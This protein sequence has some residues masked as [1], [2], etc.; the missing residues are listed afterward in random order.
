[1]K[2]IISI[3][4]AVT[5]ILWLVGAGL[6]ALVPVAKAAVVD[7]DVVS[8]DATFVDADGNTYYSYDVFIVKIVGTK[9]FKRLVLNPQ[10]FDSYGHLK[11]SNIKKIAAA[12]VA[13]YTTSSIV[14]EIN[15]TKVY[16]LVPDGDTGTKQW[17]DDLACFTSKAYDW[18]SVY[19]INATDRDNYTTGSSLCGVAVAGALTLSLASD[20]PAA[21]TV[22]PN[23]QGLTFLKVNV[24]GSGTVNQVT[25]TRKG[26]GDVGDFGD[27]YIYKDGVRLTSG[28]SLSS[29]TS[30]VTFINLG[31]AAPTTFDV[32]VDMSTGTAGNINYFIIESASEVTADATIGGTFPISGNPMGVSGTNAGTITM[33]RSGAAARNVT[34]GATEQEISQFK[35]TTATEGAYVKIVR[36]FNGG[37]ADNNLITNLK[38]KN[39]AGTTVATATS[40]SS[41]GYADFV[42][43]TPFFISKGDNEIFRVYA[44]IGG[45]KPD[46]TVILYAEIATDILATGNVYGYGMAATI[47]GFD[48]TGEAVTVTC[49]G[50]DLTLNDLGPNAANIG[51]TSSDTVFLE[52]SMTAAADITIKR[53][54]LI[55]CHDDTGN[56]TYENASGSAGADIED[57]KIRNK[58][59]GVIVVG[60]KDG[61]AFNDATRT[62]CP[63]TKT[64]VYEDFTDTIDISAGE[65]KTYQVTGDIKVA[66]TDSGV[67]IT[68]GDIIKFILYS[69]ASLVGVSGNVN[70]MKYAGTSDAVDDSAIA[71]SGDIAGEQMTIA[72]PSLAL[73]LGASPSGGDAT[74]DEKV[75]IA[76]QSGVEAVGIVFTAGSAS[77]ITINSIQLTGYTVEQTGGAFAAGIDTNYVK[78]T[79]AKVYIYDKSTGELVTGS[80][81]KGFTS[82]TSFEQVDY[83]GLSWVIPAGTQKTLLVKADISSAA[84]ASASSADTWISFDIATAADD[85]TAIDKDGNSVTTTGDAPNGAAGTDVIV[86]FGVADYGTL[87]IDQ[88]T[89]TPDKSLAV[90]GTTDNEVSKF[91]LSGVSEA[92]Y[93]EKFSIVLDDGGGIDTDDR[94]NFSAVKVKYQTESQ[95]GTSNWTISSG[96]TFGSTASLAFTF[97]GSDRVYVPKDNDTYVTILASIA[98]YNGGM[99]AKSKVPFKLYDIDG[100]D[101]SLKAYGAQSGK[102]LTEYSTDSAAAADFNLHFVTR[103]KPVFAKSAWS[104]GELEL[105]RF[106]ITAVGYDVIFDG[107]T[108][109]ETDYTSAALRFDVVASS[110]DA[111][112]IDL[113]LYDWNENIVAST[114]QTFSADAGTLDGFDGSVTS[115]SF[116]FEERDATVPAGTTKEFHIDIDAGSVADFVKTDEYIYLQLRNDDGGNLATG[117]M[118]FGE[119]DAVFHDGTAEEGI[120]SVDG[121]GN[122][123]S[124]FGMPAL[125]KNIGPLP[126]TFRTLRG[127]ATP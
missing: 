89:D 56:G 24:S 7:G 78:D 104:G 81:A 82:G 74:N 3:T 14:R 16:K 60:P 35:L 9:T 125:I 34:I 96:K 43:S 92:W 48:T 26:A 123:E 126:I 90:M 52:Y 63:G 41:G 106:T 86:N 49:K 39:T 53:T 54:E 45:T 109:T 8:P 87:T 21:S 55:F 28:R 65:T 111:A 94:D 127:T 121:A 118:S 79:I 10:V 112:K 20:T 22:P 124:R 38:L 76:G 108:S 110:T 1:M 57:I 2:K 95:Y 42:L 50:G 105:A 4:L 120:T 66:N 12:T 5:T 15:D 85:V 62:N 31:L 117:S 29:A 113:T 44:D 18:D 11:W 102:L 103:S 69:Y 67:E 98:G 25:I 46:R 91:K 58:D 30:K 6:F 61:T 101:S 59:T 47:T 116:V 40:I 100:S 107:L 72:A 70:Y 71:P 122:A 77:D 37:T 36:L 17:V 73:T 83:T 19:I 97:A 88:A 80:S 75:Y 119:R 99:G 33:T 32:V 23:A 51:D 68:A 64:G 27:L 115:V 84:P 93:L 13:G 114:Y